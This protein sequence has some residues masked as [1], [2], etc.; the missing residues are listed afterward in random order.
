MRLIKAIVFKRPNMDEEKAILWIKDNEL[1]TKYG[2][3][4]H[5]NMIIVK[6]SRIKFKKLASKK[7]SDEIRVIYGFV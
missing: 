5:E 6:Q 1:H 4:T 2:I 7:I 3:I